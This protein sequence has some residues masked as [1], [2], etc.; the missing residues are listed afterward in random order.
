MKT[1]MNQMRQSVIDECTR[2]STELIEASEKRHKSQFEEFKKI[3][4][5]TLT[6]IKHQTASIV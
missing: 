2:I 1:K 3:A 6:D 4:E 5:N